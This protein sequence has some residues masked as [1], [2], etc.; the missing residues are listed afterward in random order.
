MIRIVLAKAKEAFGASSA[1]PWDAPLYQY[2]NRL[3]HLYVLRHLNGVDAYLLF[4]FADA[5]DVPNPCTEQQWQGAQRLTEKC[6]G[7]GAHR[8]RKSVGTLLLSVPEMISRARE[9]RA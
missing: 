1:A 9:P 7:P 5:P 4:Y 2:A 8:Y 3:A 6:L